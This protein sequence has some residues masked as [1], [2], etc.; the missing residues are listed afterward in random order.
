MDVVKCYIF[1]VRYIFSAVN[2]DLCVSSQIAVLKYA[3]CQNLQIDTT[4]TTI[5]SNYVCKC[6]VYGNNWYKS[7][8]VNGNPLE[9]LGAKMVQ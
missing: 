6:S 9:L 3:H 5:T 7:Q 2:A 1:D 4:P 8:V